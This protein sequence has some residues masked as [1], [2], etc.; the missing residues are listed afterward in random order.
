MNVWRL[1]IGIL[2]FFGLLVGFNGRSAARTPTSVDT[3][4]PT[5]AVTPRATSTPATQAVTQTLTLTVT[6][7]MGPVVD[8]QLAEK[9]RAL[10][11][12]LYC[13]I[14]HT[15]PAAATGGKFGPTHDHIA[16]TAQTRVADPNYKGA[17]H[18][19]EQYL[20]ES[21]TTPRA[22][23]VTGFANTSHPMPTYAHLGMSDLDALVYFLLQQK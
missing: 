13:G 9:G 23:L 21:I 15:L 14:C 11:L 3:A 7:S 12:K 20:L 6:S 5:P 17:A 1:S 22:Y 8:Q 10:Y 16:T 2:L 4:K 19:A 18:T